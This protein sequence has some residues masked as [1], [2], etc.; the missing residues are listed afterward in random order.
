MYSMCYV[1][2]ADVPQLQPSYSRLNVIW[3]S[4]R[5]YIGVVVQSHCCL[6]QTCGAG[7]TLCYHRSFH[8][9]KSSVVVLPELAI[10]WPGHPLISSRASHHSTWLTVLPR[11]PSVVPSPL[12]SS[13]PPLEHLLDINH[14]NNY[15]RN[16]LICLLER[17][18][19]QAVP[20]WFQF[21]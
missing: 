10:M 12:C 14:H 3:W 18:Q 6:G 9:S 21:D 17:D 11:L 20:P 19:D 15:K 16:S 13:P 4:G 7:V 5:T 8:C 1:W 2:L